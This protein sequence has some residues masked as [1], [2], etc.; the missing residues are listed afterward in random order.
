M[1]QE[2]VKVLA[3]PI[4][5]SSFVVCFNV[6]QLILFWQI[7]KYLDC[8]I[9]HEAKLQAFVKMQITRNQPKTF[10]Y[11]RTFRELNNITLAELPSTLIGQ[12]LVL[13][14]SLPVESLHTLLVCS[15]VS[16]GLLQSQ[17]APVTNKFCPWRVGRSEASPVATGDLVV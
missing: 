6:V 1:G 2:M 13:N 7:I 12:T 3:R 9:C 14:C 4:N 11:R 8:Q 5:V 10:Q 17:L 16:V 15:T